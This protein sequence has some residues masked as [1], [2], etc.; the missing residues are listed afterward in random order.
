M[1]AIQKLFVYVAFVVGSMAQAHAQTPSPQ[2]FYDFSGPYIGFKAGANVSSASGAVDKATHTTMFPG[3]VAGWLFNVGPVVLGAEAF[4]DLHHGSATF[5]DGGVDAKIGY[6]V[7]QVMPYAR[8]GFTTDW[9]ATGLHGGLG[10]EYKFARDW[11]VFGEWTHDSAHAYGSKWVNDS[12]TLG[13]NLHLK[14]LL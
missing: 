10:V 14:N 11:S 7:G 1:K 9:P 2:P 12:F 13:L 4:A 6:P 8:L 5:K 3:F